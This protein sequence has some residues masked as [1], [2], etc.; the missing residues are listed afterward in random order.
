MHGV[1]RKTKVVL[2]TI[3]VILKKDSTS[4]NHAARELDLFMAERK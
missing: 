3:D 2:E 4:K 1:F